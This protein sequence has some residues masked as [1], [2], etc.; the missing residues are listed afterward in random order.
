MPP[1]AMMI[2]FDETNSHNASPDD[3]ERTLVS[4][5]QKT[6]TISESSNLPQRESKNVHF[7]SS[8]IVRKIN[9][10]RSYTQEERAAV[11]FSAAECK[12]IRKS[13]VATV[14]KMCKGIDVDA[15]ENDCSR[16]LEFKTPQKN[17]IRQT[18]KIDIIC[19]VIIEQQI[20]DEEGRV[21]THDL[22]D[23]YIQSN[24]SCI[25]EAR[26]RGDEDEC[27]AWET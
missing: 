1:I 14:K 10:H 2:Q 19:I 17:K 27:A 15:D 8:V 12:A 7:K 18:R 20:Q 21:D 22:A 26:S 13:A 3:S 25:A 6:K 9:T 11:W 16:G 4:V 24:Q 23:A 5:V